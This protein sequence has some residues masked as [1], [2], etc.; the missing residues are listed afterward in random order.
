M[1]G[2]GTGCQVRVVTFTQTILILI[3]QYHIPYLPLIHICNNVILYILYYIHE[4][5]LQHVLNNK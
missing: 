5:F 2:E 3:Q 4:M 1:R